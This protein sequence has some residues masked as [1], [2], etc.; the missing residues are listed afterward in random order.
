MNSPFQRAVLNSLLVLTL[1]H[2]ALFAVG[3]VLVLRGGVLPDVLGPVAEPQPR[4]LLFT[5]SLQ[6]EPLL[7]NTLLGLSGLL[8][9]SLL[10][11]LAVRGLYSKTY[12]PEMLFAM[13]FAACLCLDAWRLGILLARAWGLGTPLTAL[14]TRLVLFGRFFGL[15]CLLASSLYAVGMRFSQY[16]LLIGGICLLAFS[17]A[18]LL[19]LD[20]TV[21]EWD[22]LYRVGD[23]RGYLFVRIILAVLI[24]ANFLVAV[25][26]RGSR[27]Y[28][29]VALAGILLLAG[30][31]LTQHG[32]APL[33][34]ALG[35]GLLVVG[36]VL[37]TRQIGV[38]YLGV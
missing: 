14:L 5:G 38:F 6:P 31:E 22:M 7:R 13:L 21:L 8:V 24:S 2:V 16:G 36:Y 19:P 27:R 4:W 34:A 29:L 1:L 30:K 32:V 15:L 10:A 17:L 25:R 37:F 18:S 26:Q 20:A 33:P 23:R 35:T 28:L 12:A 9:F 11:N 3:V